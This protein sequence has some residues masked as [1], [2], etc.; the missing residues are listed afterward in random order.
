MSDDDGDNADWGEVEDD[1]DAGWGEV[2]GEDNPEQAAKIEIE[3]LYYEADG[4]KLF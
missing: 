3:N 1:G 2:E 4:I